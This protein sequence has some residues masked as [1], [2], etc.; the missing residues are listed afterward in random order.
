MH[1]SHWT[2]LLGKDLSTQ[3]CGWRCVQPWS[4][5]TG[6]MSLCSSW[7]PLQW[8]GSMYKFLGISPCLTLWQKKKRRVW[9][10]SRENPASLRVF[11]GCWRHLWDHQIPQ[12]QTVW[13]EMCCP[14]ILCRLSSTPQE[15]RKLV[16]KCSLFFYPRCLISAGTALLK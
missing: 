16:R 6:N 4:G 8:T 15:V 13:C 1:A 2:I 3:G 10:K 5:V 11:L 12:V 14:N 9:G 7:D